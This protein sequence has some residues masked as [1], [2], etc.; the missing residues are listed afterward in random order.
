M[1]FTEFCAQYIEIHCEIFFSLIF[2]LSYRCIGNDWGF[3]RRKKEKKVYVI[4]FY[5]LIRK[6][7]KEEDIFDLQKN[8]NIMKLILLLSCFVE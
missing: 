5:Q 6:F 2:F 3:L 4:F 8:N 1:D 7:G